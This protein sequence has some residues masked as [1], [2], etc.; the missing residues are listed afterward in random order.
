M[1]RT[2]KF[3]IYLTLLLVLLELSWFGLYYTR[4]PL[5]LI[6]IVIETMGIV[7]VGYGLHLVNSK[8]N[9]QHKGNEYHF[10]YIDSNPSADDFL[11]R[12]K[13]RL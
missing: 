10:Y 2:A 6:S 11:D 4:S 3:F 9:N 12:I 13:K 5:Y 1:N 7:L 8:D